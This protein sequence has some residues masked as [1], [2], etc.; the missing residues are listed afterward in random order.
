MKPVRSSIVIDY[1]KAQ[2]NDNQPVERV[3]EFL[4]RAQIPFE[5]KDRIYETV[6]KLQN[7][8]NATFVLGELQTMGL[9]Q[10]LFNVVSEFLI[11]KV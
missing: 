6:Q 11:A 3:F 9:N 7:G 10:E 5:L 4:N 2:L 1:I 8:R